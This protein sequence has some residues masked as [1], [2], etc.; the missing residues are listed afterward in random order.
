VSDD[1]YRLERELRRSV[2]F[3]PNEQRGLFQRGRFSFAAKRIVSACGKF[4]L[5]WT[6]DGT[7]RGSVN[8]VTI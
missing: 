2:F 8:V 4:A 3:L 5:T 6:D 1:K 7:K